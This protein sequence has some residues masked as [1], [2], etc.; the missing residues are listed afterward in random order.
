MAD[1]VRVK[2]RTS[3]ARMILRDA[4]SNPERATG[5]DKVARVV[6]N[7]IVSVIVASLLWWTSQVLAH[8]VGDDQG[9]DN[10]ETAT[11]NSAQLLTAC[12]LPGDGQGHGPALSYT[13]NGN[14]T[15]KDNVTGLLWEKT[16]NSGIVG[17]YGWRL[18]NVK[19]L[20]SIINYGIRYPAISQSIFGPVPHAATDAHF[21][22]WSS[23]NTMRV[24]FNGGGVNLDGA[25]PFVRAV[26][27]VSANCFPGDGA[28]HGRQL[29]Y[30]NNG[31]GTI[32]DNVTGLMW[33]QT[34]GVP[35]TMTANPPVTDVNRTYTWSGANTAFIAQMNA[36]RIG[37]YN[38][39]RLPDVKELESISDYALTASN[40]IFGPSTRAFYWS[41]TPHTGSDTCAWGVSGGG[42]IFHNGLHTL[43]FARAV[44]GGVH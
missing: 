9:Q 6:T 8:P 24:D 21:D 35:G 15:V 16:I 28:G 11:D 38:D 14:G 7:I 30:T 1:G 12:S 25:A 19:E 10:Q 26:G 36:A 37:G 43:Q 33:E 2:R 40:P 20:Q 27:L 29:S 4:R 23:T 32:T 39:W 42:L 31:D 3:G 41:S 17:H 13:D 22:Y 18:P 44:R 5:G 34:T